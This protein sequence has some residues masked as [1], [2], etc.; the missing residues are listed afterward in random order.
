M[1]LILGKMPFFTSPPQTPPPP[2][3]PPLS[4]SATATRF[5]AHWVVDALAG[6]ETLE[7]SVLKGEAPNL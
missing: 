3:M 7:F 1:D 6:D 2:T 4:A 5:A